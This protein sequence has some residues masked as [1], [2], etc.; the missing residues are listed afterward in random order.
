MVYALQRTD[1]A[2]V[3]DDFAFELVPILP[4]MVVLDHDDHHIKFFQE[5]FEVGILVLGYLM[6][7]QERV[8]AFQRAGKVALLCFE[9]LKGRRFAEVIYILLVGESVQ[10]HPAVVGDAVGLHD[11]M[12]TVEYEG[13]LTV[14]GLHRLVNHFGQLG[15]IAH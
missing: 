11:F 9:H 7:F 14:V 1:V 3:E 12:D 4:D 6:I 15:I 8:V 2:A 10:A 13:R 5:F